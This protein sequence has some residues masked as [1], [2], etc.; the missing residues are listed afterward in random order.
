MKKGKNRI[1]FVFTI[2]CICL[3]IIQM[4]VNENVVQAK[5]VELNKNQLNLITGQEETLKLKG[6]KKKIQWST[7][8]K[9]VATVNANGVVKA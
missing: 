6:T 7:S 2:I 3:I 8:N 4:V 5:K 9:K 1:R